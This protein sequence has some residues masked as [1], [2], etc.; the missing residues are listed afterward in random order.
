[1]KKR[2]LATTLILILTYSIAYSQTSFNKETLENAI[3]NYV[4]TENNIETE[5]EISQTI[6]PLRFQQQGVTATISHTDQLIGN[7]KVLLEFFHGNNLIHQE[8]IRIKVRVFVSVPVANKFIPKDKEINKNDITLQ[9]ADVT[10]INPSSVPDINEITNKLSK[11][12]IAKGKVIQYTDLM[13]NSDVNIKR[14]DKV[15][16]LHYSGTI[17]IKTEGTAMESGTPGSIIK[18]K[19][20]HQTLHG[21]IAD[22]GKVIVEER[23]KLVSNN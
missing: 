15:Q 2:L 4:K 6:K 18:V 14:N 11:N 21:F 5:V 10:F 8:S 17:L 7:T 9:L 3:I 13:T 23:N 1:M 12:G 19:R 20:G 22:D 16:I